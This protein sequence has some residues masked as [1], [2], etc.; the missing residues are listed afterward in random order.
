[1]R[2]K[3]LRMANKPLWLSLDKYVMDLLC[4]N[5]RDDQKWKR[6]VREVKE[7]AESKRK[8]VIAKKGQGSGCRDGFRRQTSRNYGSGGGRTG[9]QQRYVEEV[10]NDRKECNSGRKRGP[11]T[12]VERSHICELNPEQGRIF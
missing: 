12:L 7:E 9:S 1:M 10:K 3:I 8:A 2:I 4:N 11:V 5:N 6:A